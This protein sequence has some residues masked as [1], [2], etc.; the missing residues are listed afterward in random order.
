MINCQDFDGGLR[1]VMDGFGH[2]RPDPIDPFRWDSRLGVQFTGTK[3][4]QRCAII[5]GG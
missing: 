2:M 1:N 5:I 3:A 4:L